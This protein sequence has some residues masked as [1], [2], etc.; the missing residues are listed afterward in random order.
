[1]GC[2]I[3]M[4][5]TNIIVIAVFSMGFVSLSLLP[6]YASSSK[7][8]IS[9]PTIVKVSLRPTA[10]PTPSTSPSFNS[11]PSSSAPAGPSAF[12]SPTFQSM[13]NQPTCSNGQ[14]VAD[15]SQCANVSAK[16]AV[17]ACISSV[18][19][20]ALLDSTKSKD[21][22]NVGGSVHVSSTFISDTVNS[23]MQCLKLN[24]ASKTFSLGTIH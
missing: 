6:G 17:V 16:Q 20:N 13:I 7:H 10:L 14:I 24:S 4:D 8:S 23:V 12:T 11:N 18:I 22:S 19:K 15:A 21:L 9:I 2:N 5:K 1:M 3:T